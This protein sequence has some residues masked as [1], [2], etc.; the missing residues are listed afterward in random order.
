MKKYICII[1][2]II[3]IIAGC[4]RSY[5]NSISSA[6][7]IIYVPIKDTISENINIARIVELEHKCYILKDSINIIR[8]SL[9]TTLDSLNKNLFVAKYKLD[10]IKYYN[11]IA[12]KGNNIKYLRGWINRVI[13]DK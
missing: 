12:R 6:E 2:G 13:N 1:I 9:T 11:D 4:S 3:F 5:N 7:K 8:D 10:R